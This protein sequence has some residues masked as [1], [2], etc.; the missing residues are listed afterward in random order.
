VSSPFSIVNGSN[1]KANPTDPFMPERNRGERPQPLNSPLKCNA[2]SGLGLSA[3]ATISAAN[4]HGPGRPAS[5]CS[6]SGGPPGRSSQGP[7]SMF[8]R[9]C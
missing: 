5:S 9:H 4:G 6:T 2:H 1:Q 7:G 3:G 8:F